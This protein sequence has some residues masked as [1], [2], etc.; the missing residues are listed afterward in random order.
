MSAYSLSGTLCV[1]PA[2]EREL[3][4]NRLCVNAPRSSADDVASFA[5]CLP[6]YFGR[7]S[8]GLQNLFAAHGFW[9]SAGEAL[10]SVKPYSYIRQSYVTFWK[11]PLTGLLA[12]DPEH[13]VAST[14]GEVQRI[15]PREQV[16]GLGICIAR[17]S[18]GFSLKNCFPSGP[19]A[20]V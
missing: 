20:E 18:R 5:A 13:L 3:F 15:A 1:G 2:P 16:E 9:L 11:H 8:F 12:N 19:A 6:G 17:T 7:I 4:G 10:L 14:E